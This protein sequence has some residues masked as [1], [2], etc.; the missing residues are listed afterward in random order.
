MRQFPS[1]DLYDVF[2]KDCVRALERKRYQQSDP[3]LSSLINLRGRI[4]LH[5][6]NGCVLQH[7]QRQRSVFSRNRELS[8]ENDN[9]GFASFVANRAVAFD[10]IFDRLSERIASGGGEASSDPEKDGIAIVGE[11]CGGGIQKHVALTKFEKMFVVFAVRVDGVWRDDLVG[12]CGGFDPAILEI[13][14]FPEY[15]VTIDLDDE[16][17]GKDYIDATTSAIDATCPFAKELAWRRI[18]EF[19][20]GGRDD[21][22]ARR[23]LYALVDETPWKLERLV[24]LL[25]SDELDEKEID[26][27]VCGPGEGVVWADSDKPW[28]TRHWCKTKGATHRFGLSAAATALHHQPPPPS[29]DYDGDR[30]K[31]DAFV[32]AHVPCRL[33]QGIEF[34]VEHNKEVS[35]INVRTFVW[36]VLEDVRKE[37]RYEIDDLLTTSTSVDKKTLDRTI[38]KHAVD[39]F[40]RRL[41]AS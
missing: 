2:R 40:K 9:A 39:W 22:A 11:F 26:A 10:G 38:T 7:Q 25:A 1:I 29:K 8:V 30:G 13:S 20:S 23:L 35:M 34:L 3:D 32:H 31:V 37:C 33:E 27:L 19:V 28:E 21:A 12:L 15:R 18:R 41:D 6:T 24:E 17:V 36:F 4:K 16:R 5:G 14:A